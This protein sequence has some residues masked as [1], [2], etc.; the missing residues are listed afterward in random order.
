MSENTRTDYRPRMAA[1]TWIT[2]VTDGQ[3]HAVGDHDN[4]IPKHSYR[5]TQPD[6]PAFCGH[7]VTERRASLLV[8]PGPRCTKCVA[9]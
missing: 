7:R 4:P 9:R 3:E 6:L 5:R 2:S 8:P 1:F